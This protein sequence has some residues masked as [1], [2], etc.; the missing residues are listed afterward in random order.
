MLAEDFWCKLAINLGETNFYK[1]FK[2]VVVV[3]FILGLIVA[4]LASEGGIFKREI[5][6]KVGLRCVFY[7]VVIGIPSVATLAFSNPR[8]S[9]LVVKRDSLLMCKL[10]VDFLFI[11]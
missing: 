2:F 11:G 3:C 10:A 5:E 6:L 7:L 4:I 8:T 1:M 9:F